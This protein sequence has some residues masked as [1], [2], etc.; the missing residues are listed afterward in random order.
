MHLKEYLY[1]YLLLT[2][3]SRR[4]ILFQMLCNTV[5]LPSVRI[6]IAIDAAN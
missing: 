1:L 3:A 4:A 6:V 5:I 2:F